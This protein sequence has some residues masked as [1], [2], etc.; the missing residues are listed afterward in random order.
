MDSSY[1]PFCLYTTNLQNAPYLPNYRL[2]QHEWIRLIRIIQMF[3]NMLF[4]PYT[5]NTLSTYFNMLN[6]LS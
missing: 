5:I 6:V 4:T 2:T 1:N 3:L